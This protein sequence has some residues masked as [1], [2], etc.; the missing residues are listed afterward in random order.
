MISDEIGVVVI[1]RN[2]GARLLDC[3]MSLKSKRLKVVSVLLAAVLIHPYAA[4]LAV[5]YVLQIIRIAW[6][7]GPRLVSSWNYAGFIVIGKFA[8]LQ[9]IFYWTLG[10]GKNPTRIDYKNGSI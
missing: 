3:L 6:R 10:Q 5:I 9:G 7:R 4:V 8:E 2:A 1:G